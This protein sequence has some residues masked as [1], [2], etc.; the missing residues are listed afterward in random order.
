M[1]VKHPP[2]QGGAVRVH[3]SSVMHRGDATAGER[4]RA[5]A[6]RSSPQTLPRTARLRE[7]TWHTSAPSATAACAPGGQRRRG[8][9][10]TR[11]LMTLIGC[12]TSRTGRRCI[13]VKYTLSADSGASSMVVTTRVGREGSRPTRRPDAR[14]CPVTRKL[15]QPAAGM[16]PPARRTA[17]LTVG[18]GG[19]GRPY[20]QAWSVPVESWW[21]AA[22]V[23]TCCCPATAGHHHDSGSPQ[24]AVGLAGP[25]GP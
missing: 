5:L 7:T 10:T 19:E 13:F 9:D 6:V 17:Y 1:N 4:P 12:T 22:V 8:P 21:F 14:A 16:S 11:T 25:G 15:C 24:G 2:F 18:L 23:V 3:D 20:G